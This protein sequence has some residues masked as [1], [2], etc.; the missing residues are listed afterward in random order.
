MT[1]QP[2]CIGQKH[3]KPKNIFG[4]MVT[5]RLKC[6]FSCQRSFYICLLGFEGHLKI[7]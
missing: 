7:K 2:F 4:S 6:F 1:G 3:G 5:Q